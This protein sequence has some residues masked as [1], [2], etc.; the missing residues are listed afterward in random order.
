M[1]EVA[2]GGRTVVLVSHNNAAVRK[3]C[4]NAILL[5]EG[6]ITLEGRAT[7]VLEEYVAGGVR[8]DWVANMP[9]PADGSAPGRL[10]SLMIEDGNGSAA[11]A[12]PVGRPWQVRIE[13]AIERPVEH[14]MVALGLRTSE[15]VQLRTSWSKPRTLAPGHYHALFREEAI[16]L[17]TGHYFMN[18]GLSSNERTFH[19]VETAGLLEVSGVADGVDLVR[20]EGVGAVLNPMPVEIAQI[21]GPRE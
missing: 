10:V 4:T 19:Y 16:W 3:L 14:F 5:D 13:F 7:L 18:V 2:T 6:R 17:G 8:G 1:D 20:V 21:D 15:D 12:I 11:R 9:P